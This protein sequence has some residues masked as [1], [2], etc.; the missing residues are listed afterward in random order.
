MLKCDV[1]IFHLRK[2]R[3]FLSFWREKLNFNTG[4]QEEFFDYFWKNP[5]LPTP[6]ENIL[7][8][9]MLSYAKI[10]KC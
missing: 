1:F 7:M 8:T 9:P 5:L 10:Q 6:Q 3:C 4:V 2:K